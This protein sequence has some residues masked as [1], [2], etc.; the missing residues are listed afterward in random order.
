MLVCAHHTAGAPLTSRHR[1]VPAPRE[2]GESSLVIQLAGTRHGAWEYIL[3]VSAHSNPLTRRTFTR[4][5]PPHPPKVI[6][7]Y[8]AGAVGVVHG[9]QLQNGEGQSGPGSQDDLPATAGRST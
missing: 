1:F 4:Y 2:R 7:V 5:A 8:Q 3:G 9:K 6:N